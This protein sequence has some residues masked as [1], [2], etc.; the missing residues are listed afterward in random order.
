MSVN[1]SLEEVD[2][3]AKLKAEVSHINFLDNCSHRFISWCGL[4]FD[5]YT[6][7]VYL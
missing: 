6:L 3:D 4:D 7:D 1:S 5:L 2:C